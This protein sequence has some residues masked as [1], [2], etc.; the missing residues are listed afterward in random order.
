MLKGQEANAAFITAAGTCF[1]VEAAKS[2]ASLLAR[3][4]K[5]HQ[6]QRGAMLHES[7]MLRFVPD[8]CHNGVCD[9]SKPDGSS[10]EARSDS[11]RIDSADWWPGVDAG[12]IVAH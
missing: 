4:F 6:Q 3:S 9:M 1:V 2:V 11:G 5:L 7:E 8:S 10:C 12:I